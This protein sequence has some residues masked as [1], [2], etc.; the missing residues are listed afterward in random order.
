MPGQD[1]IDAFNASFARSAPRAH[2][3]APLVLSDDG[4]V[5]GQFCGMRLESAFEVLVDRQG[6][7]SGHQARLVV[8]GPR[9]RVVSAWA[10]YA[11]ALDE[12]AIVHLDRLV[13]TLH[14]LNGASLAALGPLFLPLHPRHVAEV[15]DAHG[16]VFVGI[17]R[18]CGLAAAHVVL[19]LA[20]AGLV[21]PAHLERA[22]AR[23]RARGFGIALYEQAPGADSAVWERVQPGFVVLGAPFVAAAEAGS[24]VLAER[25]DA[26]HRFGARAY[27][28]GVETPTQA[29]LARTFGADAWQ[30]AAGPQAQHADPR[31]M[32]GA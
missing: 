24:Q 20:D 14:V 22:M 25:I 16:E 23:F 21:A 13:R 29:A 28:R 26:V 2:A 17:L 9:G 11:V 18:D 3:P 8:Y 19:E 27:V 6:R 7:V 31:T 32:A 30:R 15:R 1:L 10:P 4:A 12:A 5:V